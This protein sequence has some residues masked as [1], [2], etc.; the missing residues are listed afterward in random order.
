[1]VTFFAFFAEDQICQTYI[2]FGFNRWRSVV[3]YLSVLIP[4]MALCSDFFFN[5]L[6]M[7]QRH[8]FL[9]VFILLLYVFLSFLG[10][11]AQ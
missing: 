4:L 3:L 10:S 2:D 6:V 11:V 7:G 5:R 1:V 9:N 8:A